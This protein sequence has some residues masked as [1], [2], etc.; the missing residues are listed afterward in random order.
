MFLS[1]R[2]H[3]VSPFPSTVRRDLM[4]VIFNMLFTN[5]SRDFLTN[6]DWL[7]QSH[8]T[9]GRFDWFI[10][11]AEA[12]R[13]QNQCKSIWVLMCYY[14]SSNIL[15]RQKFCDDLNF[16]IFLC[17]F[18]LT[19]QKCFYK[20]TQEDI[21]YYCLGFPLFS[22]FQ[23]IFPIF[24]VFLLPFAISSTF[25]NFCM[26]FIFLLKNFLDFFVYIKHFYVK[27]KKYSHQLYI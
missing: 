20:N 14:C 21:Y 7:I 8:D 18:Y 5:L 22:V 12:Q 9:I 3:E 6:T 19:K 2:R 23:I 4:S 17:F 11:P 25:I 1:F 15:E 13:L 16:V 26:A 27:H 24:Q 10:S